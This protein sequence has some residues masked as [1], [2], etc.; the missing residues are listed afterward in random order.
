MQNES[1]REPKASEL[2]AAAGGKTDDDSRPKENIGRAGGNKECKTGNQACI[3]L[4]K[5]SC[6]LIIEV[7]QALRGDDQALLNAFLKSSY[8]ELGL[9]QLLPFFVIHAKDDVSSNLKNFRVLTYVM[10]AIY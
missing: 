10:H 6:T 7:T 2:F 3:R 4:G 1:I 5:R 8:E 9:Q